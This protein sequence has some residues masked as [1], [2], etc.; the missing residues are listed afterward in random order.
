MYTFHKYED[1]ARKYSKQIEEHLRKQKDFVEKNGLDLYYWSDKNSKSVLQ[2]YY[3]FSKVSMVD[4]IYLPK[5][6]PTLSIPNVKPNEATNGVY[7][8]KPSSK[9]IGNSN[10]ILISKDLK[11]LVDYAKNSEGV[12]IIQKEIKPD[13]IN[14]FKYDIR[15]YV[16]IVYNNSILY[17]YIY[18]GILRFCK[19]KY[20]YGSTEVDRQITIY[21]DFKEMTSIDEGIKYILYKTLL[22]LK[23]QSSRVGYQYLGYDIIKDHKG[24]YHLIEINIQPS[25]ERIKYKII[26]DFSKLVARPIKTEQGYEPFMSTNGSIILSEL[27]MSHLDSLCE[28]TSDI[29]VMKYIGNLQIWSRQKTQRFI[30]Y[31]NNKDYYYLAILSHNLFIGII[32]RN[33]NKLT[34]YLSPKYFG[35]GLGKQALQLFLKLVTIDLQADVLLCNTRSVNLF[36]P[37]RA[38]YLPNIIRYHLPHLT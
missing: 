33:H 23:P 24:N 38:E 15:I 18:P 20:I 11:K 36:K 22:H 10:G 14:G 27:N 28:I 5:L 21:G 37:Y 8:L 32:G 9:F 4:K 13:L 12:Y 16:L 19:D 30:Q 3:P 7:F 1:V 34:I 17:I 35:Q 6:F 29:N 25:L 31:G 2:D 26:E